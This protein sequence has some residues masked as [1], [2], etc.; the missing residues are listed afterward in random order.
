[1]IRMDT[2][3][4]FTWHFNNRERES[5]IVYYLFQFQTRCPARPV[6]PTRL[7]SLSRPPLD[8][9]APRA[10]TRSGSP[11]MCPMESTLKAPP[12][13]LSPPITLRGNRP[14]TPATGSPTVTTSGRR[15]MSPMK[16][17]RGRRERRTPRAKSRLKGVCFEKSQCWKVFFSWVKRRR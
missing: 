15:T 13:A 9:L 6:P 7:I 5:T 11:T 14:A 4:H 16:R 12:M 10:L 1:M 8:P 17:T 3:L 2:E